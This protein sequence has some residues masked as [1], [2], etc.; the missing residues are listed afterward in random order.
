MFNKYDF[1][2][3]I[4]TTNRIIN[5]IMFLYDFRTKE[6]YFTRM[7]KSKMKF[8]DIILFILN[9]VKKSLQ[10]ELDDFFKKVL[11]TDVIVTKQA[12]SQARR[13]VLPEAFIY[14]LDKVNEGFYNVSFKK[15]HGYRLLAIDGTMLE[16]HNSEELRNTFGYIENQNA[17]VARAKASALYDIENDM[18]IASKLTHYRASERDIAET[19]INK[20]YEFESHN[21]L[22]LFDRGYPSHDFIKFIESK[23]IKYLMRV[24]SKFFK[25]VVNAPN[26]D[27]IMDISYK[28]SSVKMRVLKFELDSGITEILITNIFNEDFI[29]ADFKELYFK[30]WGIEVKYNEIKNKLQIENFTGETPIA[31][32][33]DFYATMYLANMVALAKQDANQVIEEKYKEK[34]LKYE[35]KVNTNVLIGKLKDTLIT[36]IAT[37]NPWKRSRML[38]Y[39]EEEIQ[40]NVIPVRPDRKFKRKENKS[41]QMANR[42]NKKRAL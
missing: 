42:M 30:R 13:K 17:K 24:S 31:I 26:E 36:M 11:D 3:G 19:L 14:L 20:M 4:N 37:N 1:K 39:I 27:Q 12:F 41:T 40:R 6:T 25:A 15:Y 2:E 29:V 33:Q 18:I 5:D 7:G 32:E 23:N 9:F 21:D 10:I 16:I 28:G 38:K 8:T 35:Y 34:K 22:I